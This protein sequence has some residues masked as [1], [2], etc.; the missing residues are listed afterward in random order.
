MGEKSEFEFKAILTQKSLQ[1]FHLS[2]VLIN[3]CPG[4]LWSFPGDISLTPSGFFQGNLAWGGVE[5]DG[6]G[7]AS[8]GF[9]ILVTFYKSPVRSSTNV[10]GTRAGF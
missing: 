4:Y 8:T 7:W 3:S 5:W 2:N 1:F 9:P 10:A 6:V